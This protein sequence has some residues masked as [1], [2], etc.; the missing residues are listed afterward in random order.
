MENIEMLG[1][2]SSKRVKIISEIRF[3]YRRLFVID[4]WIKTTLYFGYSNK[5]L[6]NYVWKYAS[7]V[8]GYPLQ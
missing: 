6:L 5:V 7:I 4:N 1:Y 3:W 8:R 2:L